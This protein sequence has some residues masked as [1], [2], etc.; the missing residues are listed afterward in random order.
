MNDVSKGV[1]VNVPVYMMDRKN[2]DSHGSSQTEIS[3]YAMRLNE[4]MPKFTFWP[5]GKEVI[6]R[7]IMRAATAESL[8]EFVIYQTD[9]SALQTILF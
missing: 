6:H 8:E 2:Y 1:L 3:N 5:R 4:K 9:G 7:L